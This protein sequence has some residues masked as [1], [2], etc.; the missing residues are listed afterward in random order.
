MIRTINLE[1]RLRRDLESLAEPE[2]LEVIAGLPDMLASVASQSGGTSA[3]TLLEESLSNTI[4]ISEPFIV[5][6][7]DATQALEQSFNQC[8]P[9]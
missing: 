5:R 2:D 6:G 9:T 7:V 8:L 4:R 3:L 1:I